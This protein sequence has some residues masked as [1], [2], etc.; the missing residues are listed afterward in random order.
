MAFNSYLIL[1]YKFVILC[2]WFHFLAYT[3]FIKSTRFSQN[4][5]FLKSVYALKVLHSER[6][7]PQKS[8]VKDQAQQSLCPQISEAKLPPH[9]FTKSC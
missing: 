6:G 8:S 4:N 3:A 9:H 1:Y 5:I 2:I 7:N